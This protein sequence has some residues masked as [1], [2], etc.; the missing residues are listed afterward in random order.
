MCTNKQSVINPYTNQIKIGSLKM[1][2][3]IKWSLDL[4][5]LFW[6]VTLAYLKTLIHLF[7]F[8]TKRWHHWPYSCIV[9]PK[10]RKMVITLHY[11]Y[12]STSYFERSND[13]NLCI[14][15]LIKVCKCILRTDIKLFF[16]QLVIVDIRL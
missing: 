5:I 13:V 14:K 1:Y 4:D 11:K 15:V 6:L 7:L 8:W 10:L 9:P 16:I 2:Q 12:I 3:D